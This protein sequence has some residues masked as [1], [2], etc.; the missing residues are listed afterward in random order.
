MSE[1]EE[2]QTLFSPS[3]LTFALQSP[4]EHRAALIRTQWTQIPHKLHINALFILK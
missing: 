2:G 4:I 3:N 1:G